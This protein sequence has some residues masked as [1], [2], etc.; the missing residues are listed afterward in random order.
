MTCPLSLACSSLTGRRPTL[1]LPLS[2]ALTDMKGNK[3][4]IN[5]GLA[6]APPP[7]GWCPPSTE[8][9]IFESSASSWDPV[10]RRPPP[11]ALC[12]FLSSSAADCLGL[13]GWQRYI[14]LLISGSIG[15]PTWPSK[16]LLWWWQVPAGAA[17]NSHAAGSCLTVTLHIVN[18]MAS[19]ALKTVLILKPVWLNG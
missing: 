10:S 15:L 2:S 17:H 19:L 9:L 13:Q 16:G 3:K 18:C 8:G 11:H 6:G 7:P 4:G 14:N 5:L 1:I 12:L